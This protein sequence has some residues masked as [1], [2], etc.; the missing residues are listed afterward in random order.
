[1]REGEAEMGEVFKEFVDKVP[2]IIDKAAQSLA[3]ASLSVLVLGAL[4][5]LLFRNATGKLKLAAFAMMT[6]GLLGLFTFA[7]NSTKIDTPGPK[8]ISPE[9]TEQI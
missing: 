4:G 9:Q 7:A 1:V 5:F 6:A 2:E 8:P 3:L